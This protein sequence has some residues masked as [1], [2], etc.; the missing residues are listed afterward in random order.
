M[1]LETLVSFMATCRRISFNGRFESQLPLAMNGSFSHDLL[2]ESIY[3]NIGVIVVDIK[4][5]IP[6]SIVYI[7]W[8]CRVLSVLSILSVLKGLDVLSVCFY[9]NYCLIVGEHVCVQLFENKESLLESPLRMKVFC[10][11][12]IDLSER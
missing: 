4:H 11:K 7:L 6:L 5:F 9:V 1:S 8:R 10:Q 12:L 3:F 2:L